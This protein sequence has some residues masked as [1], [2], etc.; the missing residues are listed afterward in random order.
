MSRRVM[1]PSACR[2]PAGAQSAMTAPERTAGTPDLPGPRS[3]DRGSMTVLT[4]GVLVVILL[5]MAVGT[6]I[7]S[8][9]LERNRLQSAADGAALAASQAFGS[10]KPAV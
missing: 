2:A 4:T 3:S 5:V 9:H 10:R 1:T 6:A 8:V 7:T